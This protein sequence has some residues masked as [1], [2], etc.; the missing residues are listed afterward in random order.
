L[1]Q[2]SLLHPFNWP[3]NIL[4]WFDSSTTANTLAFLAL[5][6]SC[7]ALRKN[8]KWKNKFKENAMG[9]AYKLILDLTMQIKGINNILDRFTGI[10]I[11]SFDISHHLSS[12]SSYHSNDRMKE[13]IRTS[14]KKSQKLEEQ[15]FA[16]RCNI[17]NLR[18]NLETLGYS[19]SKTNE[20]RLNVALDNIMT[21]ES[22]LNSYITFSYDY[23]DDVE[24][25]GRMRFSQHCLLEKEE[26]M[27]KLSAMIS[28][29]C[30]DIRT[31]AEKTE[32]T[33]NKLKPKKGLHILYK[34]Q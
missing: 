29:A 27:E 9:D 25:C 16:T 17:T 33:L 12:R 6:V 10:W 11:P 32:K 5:M 30:I 24:L 8:V 34:N 15:L 3:L 22:N 26:A 2:L 1:E 4:K 18:A 13:S 28:S 23:F 31:L 19:M 21:L 7:L 20:K 14:L